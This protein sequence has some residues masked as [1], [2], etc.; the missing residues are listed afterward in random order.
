MYIP[1]RNTPSCIEVKSSIKAKNAGAKVNIIKIGKQSF[2]PLKVIPKA[3]KAIFVNKPVPVTHDSVRTTVIK[4]NGKLY[5]PIAN[6]THKQ[7]N[8]GGVVY[9][10]VH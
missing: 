5:K 7:V 8:I 2:I 1:V 3:Y 9:I 10:P 6:E 4:I